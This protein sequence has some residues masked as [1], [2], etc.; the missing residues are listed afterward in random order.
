[1]VKGAEQ[2]GFYREGEHSFTLVLYLC[3]SIYG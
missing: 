1:M 2:V 3:G